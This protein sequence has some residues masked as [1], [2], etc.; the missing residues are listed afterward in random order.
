MPWRCQAGR[1][2]EL[3][4]ED[5]VRGGLTQP[6]ARPAGQRLPRAGGHGPEMTGLRGLSDFSL[7]FCVWVV[8]LG[9]RYF[10]NKNSL[11]V[12]SKYV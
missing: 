8:P 9:T 10:S 4:P 7:F 5:P 3:E 12:K 2:A 1:W 11:N 6:W